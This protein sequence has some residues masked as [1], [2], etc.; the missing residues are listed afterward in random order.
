M[1]FQL[2]HYLNWQSAFLTAF[3]AQFPRMLDVEKWWA[4]MLVH[5]TGMDPSQAWSL[6]VAAQKLD[7]TLHPPVLVSGTP[8]ELPHR[9]RLTVQRIISE[10]DYL[11]QRIVLKG[12]INQLFVMRVKTPP[13]MITLVDEYRATI[14]AYLAKRDKAGMARSLPGLPPMRADALVR[15]VVKKLDELDQRR[16][17]SGAANPPASSTLASPAK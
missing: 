10:W 6:P 14:D 11:R 2:P 3:K 4:V 8:K 7:E 9:T 5:F 16:A 13:E 1:L 12:V 17:A 15:D